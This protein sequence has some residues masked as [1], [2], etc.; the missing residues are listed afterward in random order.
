MPW[1]EA[2][3]QTLDDK[4]DLIRGWDEEWANRT[5]FTMGIFLKGELIGATG[6]HVRGPVGVLEIGYWL[7]VDYVGHGIATMCA[8]ELTYVAFALNEVNVVEIHH[9][10]ANQASGRIP[11]KLGYVCEE[12]YERKPEAPGESGVGNRWVMTRQS[13]GHR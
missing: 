5:G 2:E 6:Y 11:E 3:P 4:E 7:G 1:I 12:T 10:V 9:D 13:W 8:R